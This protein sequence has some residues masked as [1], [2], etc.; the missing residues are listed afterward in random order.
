MFEHEPSERIMILL[1]GRVKVTRLGDG[2]Q[3]V[4]LS[5]R[6]P[7]DILGEL[8]FI[9]GEPRLA[10][11]TALEAVEVLVIGA[12]SFRLHL[13]STPRV[14]VALLEVITSRFRE[15]TVKRG[16]F[17]DLDTL[18]RLAARLMELADR[19]GSHSDAGLTIEMPM[20]QEELA[21]WVGASRAGVAQALQTM[22]QLGWITTERR[23]MVIT[24]PA[25]VRARAA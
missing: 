4:V 16:Q 3:D 17:S 9:D 6:D 7:G 8:G 12:G 11:V 5:I 2:G 24:D 23:R 20:S 18:G 15:A 13:E 10:T 22:R 21:G 14:A 19:Y 25:A 1:A